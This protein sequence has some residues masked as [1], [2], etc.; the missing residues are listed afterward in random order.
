VLR[1][2]SR[3]SYLAMLEHK[4]GAKARGAAGIEYQDKSADLDDF[5]YELVGLQGALDLF[6]ND[7]IYVDIDAAYRD[8][9]YKFGSREDELTYLRGALGLR[10][11]ALFPGG[12]GETIN[13]FGTEFGIYHTDRQSTV[14]AFDYDNTGAEIRLVYRF[15]N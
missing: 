12:A 2:G 8:Y 13:R 1:S 15:G 6:P 7:A 5:A 4:F 14:S 9:N 10:L 3:W 11:A